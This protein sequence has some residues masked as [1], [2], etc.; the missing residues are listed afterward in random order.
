MRAASRR[1]SR[2]G[3][4]KCPRAA[5]APA[6]AAAVGAAGAARSGPRG[7]AAPESS[8]GG[9]APP[10]AL[11]ARARGAVGDRALPDATAVPAGGE[12]SCCAAERASHGAGPDHDP[13]ERPG[14]GQKPIGLLRR[15]A[16]TFDLLSGVLA[17]SPSG[18]AAR[19]TLGAGH[20]PPRAGLGAGA[21]R[22]PA[23]SVT[24][25]DARRPPHKPFVPPR[26]L[27]AARPAADPGPASA[28][29]PPAAP[30]D[31]PALRAA[32]PGVEPRAATAAPVA[33]ARGQAQPP[34]GAAD[35]QPAERSMRGPAHGEGASAAAG[36]PGSV[37]GPHSCGAAAADH[38]GVGWTMARP[39]LGSPAEA[40]APAFDL[41]PPAATAV[42]YK[43]LDGP[44][45]RRAAGAERGGGAQSAGTGQPSGLG[46]GAGLPAGGVLDGGGP[47]AGQAARPAAAGQHAGG[48]ATPAPRAAAGVPA[49]ER[50]ASGLP[51]RVL[52]LQSAAAPWRTPPGGFHTPGAVGAL[53]PPA[54]TEVYRMTCCVFMSGGVQHGTYVPSWSCSCGQGMHPCRQWPF[55]PLMK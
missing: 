47:S 49:P 15:P 25:P 30:G 4:F 27:R 33:A 29:P 26:A 39:E 32:S 41:R 16:P 11:T 55:G 8:S 43:E 7:V 36:L 54:L 13:A 18:G 14:P 35:V 3:L 42:A 2:A 38:I 23:G 37:Q 22:A 21:P 19:Q 12:G 10:S 50:A 45:P 40:V 34:D 51:A 31:A 17:G 6:E 44:W 53:E 46:Q 24:A 5:T 1:P 9:D 28:A 48:A 20:A 52:A